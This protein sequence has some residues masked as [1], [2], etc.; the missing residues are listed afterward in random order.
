M[1]PGACCRRVASPAIC[2][3]TRV[4]ELRYRSC[5][6]HKSA[7][8]VNFNIERVRFR[9]FL[10]FFTNL[11][12]VHSATLGAT[13]RWAPSSAFELEMH[14][15]VAVLVAGATR[16][17]SDLKTGAAE[18]AQATSTIVVGAGDARGWGAFKVEQLPAS[19]SKRSFV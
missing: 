14:V 12:R 11:V 7:L 5:A 16:T 6:L 4:F 1:K 3:L 8:V 13:S 17:S 10:P 9:P 2:S 15:L 18:L 19:V